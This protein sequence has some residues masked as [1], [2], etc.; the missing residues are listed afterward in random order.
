[1]NTVRENAKTPKQNSIRVQGGPSITV[2]L[3]EI[4]YIAGLLNKKMDLQNSLA[5]EAALK[6]RRANWE[7]KEE[8]KYPESGHVNSKQEDLRKKYIESFDGCEITADEQRR[9]NEAQIGGVC[10]PVESRSSPK[11]AKTSPFTTY[12]LF[13]ELRYRDRPK[14]PKHSVSNLNKVVESVSANLMASLSCE[15]EPLVGSVLPLQYRVN[16]EI[17]AMALLMGFQENDSPQVPHAPLM[18]TGRV[19]G[20]TDCDLRRQKRALRAVETQ[21]TSATPFGPELDGREPTPYLRLIADKWEQGW[22]LEYR[23]RRLVHTSMTKYE[24]PYLDFIGKWNASQYCDGAYVNHF[25]FHFHEDDVIV[26][27]PSGV[28]DELGV[29]WNGRLRTQENFVL[30]VTKCKTL[31]SEVAMTPKQLF[32]ATLYAPALAFITK[33]D[34]Q[35]N[36]ARV[37]DGAYV[38]TPWHSI[39]KTQKSLRSWRGKAFAGCVLVGVSVLTWSTCL[40][41]GRA[42]RAYQ[43]GTASW[44]TREPLIPAPRLVGVEPNPGPAKQVVRKPVNCASL[45]QPKDLKPGAKI[46]LCDGGLRLKVA[47]KDPYDRKGEHVQMAFDTGLYRPTFFASNQWNEK[48]ALLARVLCNTVEPTSSLAE[49]IAW[50]KENHRGLFPRMFAIESVPFETYLERSNASPSVKRVL[51]Q[52]HQRLVSEGIDETS[53][54]TRSTLYRY[55]YRSSFV[56]SEND[57]YTSPAGRKDKAPR[58]IQGAQPEFICLVGPWIMAVQ[59]V[60][61]RRWNLD[62]FICFT[63]GVSA[64]D[65]AAFIVDGAGPWLEDDLGKFDSSIRRP[66]CEYE[67]WLAKQFG[68]KQA[69]LDLMQANISTHGSTHHGWRYKCDGTRKSGDPYTSLMNSV[70]NGLSHAFLYGRFTGRSLNQMRGSLRMLVQGDDNCMRHVEQTQFPWQQ[71]MAELGFD[72]EALYRNVVERVEF[73]SSRIYRTNLGYVFGPKPGKVLAK[74]GYIVNP[75]ATVAPES[76]MRGVALGLREMCH[77]IPPLR[78]LVE[79]TLELTEGFEAYKMA[80]ARFTPFDQSPMKIRRRHESTV[81]TMLNLHLNYDWCY[82]RQREWDSQLKLLR[83]GDEIA[84]IPELLFDRDTGG[85]QLIFGGWVAKALPEVAA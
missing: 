67:V 64:E 27:V 60:L 5:D 34:T 69:V 1:M 71:S 13:D 58:L 45:P 8:R 2:S 81:E 14:H 40:L 56:K 70:I 66:W 49:C 23:E 42:K 74:Y 37:V 79:R 46:R 26:E 57:L 3:A 4:T 44:N 24:F 61:K 20:V 80:I 11:Q 30:S 22:L 17:E 12:N 55:T 31:L 6:R 68:A 25:G 54:L 53:V 73:C 43:S 39:T 78:S 82:G 83:F 84:G 50:C 48:Q 9:V 75:P 51:L 35:Q 65:A 15:P 77:F 21:W 59:D 72:S 19:G 52:T 36:V 18:G 62:N 33:W 16:P 10:P 76:M 38:N 29:F 85:P 32:D 41:I 63:S 28:I 47:D 7:D